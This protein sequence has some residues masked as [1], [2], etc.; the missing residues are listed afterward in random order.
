MDVGR[1]K[2]VPIAVQRAGLD[3]DDINFIE[4]SAAL[5]AQACAV[6]DAL[7]FDRGKLNQNG[8]GI[9]LGE[10]IGEPAPFWW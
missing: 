5:A 10:P 7:G 8:S 4:A 1:I 6:A 2:D 9:A 3:L